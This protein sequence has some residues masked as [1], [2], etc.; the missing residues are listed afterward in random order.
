MLTVTGKK[1]TK[2]SHSTGSGDCDPIQVKPDNSLEVAALLTLAGGFLDAFTFVGHGGVFA[3]SMTA[4]F[5]FLGMFAAK[6]DLAR[7][8]DYIPPIFAFVIGVFIAHKLRYPWVIKKFPQKL[9][10]LTDPPLTCLSIEIIFLVTVLFFPPSIPDIFLVLGISVVA[11]MQNSSFNRVES[12]TYNSIMTTGNLSRC[13]E[14]FFVSTFQNGNKETRRQARLFGLIC[15]CFLAGAGIGT[16][17]T[18]KLKNAALWLPIGMLGI[19]L[20]ICLKHKLAKINS[21]DK[22]Q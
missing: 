10:K 16:I 15:F 7:A 5:V 18:L 20:S 12:W 8:V 4:N 2:V 11:A 21:F 22:G 1:L 13:A 9:K 14:A 3:N 19:A 6:G 17:S